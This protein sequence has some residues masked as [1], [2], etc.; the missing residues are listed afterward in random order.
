MGVNENPFYDYYHE[1]I[2]NLVFRT[3][4]C[5]LLLNRFIWLAGVNMTKFYI[6]PIHRM[7]EV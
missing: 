1:D 7:Y 3:F 4:F 2:L 6:T 5:S